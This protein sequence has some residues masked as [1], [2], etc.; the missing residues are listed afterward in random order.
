[1]SEF[2]DR[3]DLR[4]VIKIVKVKVEV[5]RNGGRWNEGVG[6]KEGNEKTSTCT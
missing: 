6:G 3:F 1:M 2:L 5:T 4:V